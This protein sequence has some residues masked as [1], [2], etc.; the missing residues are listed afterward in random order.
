MDPLFAPRG[1]EGAVALIERVSHGLRI[2]EPP[3]IGRLIST[4]GAPST[5]GCANRCYR[6]LRILL[7]ITRLLYKASATLRVYQ[8]ETGMVPTP[9][10]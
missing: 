6:R 5:G 1:G 3:V 8:G 7:L 4:S 2:C 9:E 10:A